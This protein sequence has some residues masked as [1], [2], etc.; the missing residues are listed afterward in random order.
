MDQS[1]LREHP[2]GDSLNALSASLGSSRGSFDGMTREGLPTDE[3]AL[4]RDKWIANTSNEDL[5]EI[6]QAAKEMAEVRVPVSS[7]RAPQSL[8]PG[9][10]ATQP[11]R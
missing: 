8:L 9:P 10:R 5:H 6:E 2:D 4:S 11:T 7:R 1:P 3:R